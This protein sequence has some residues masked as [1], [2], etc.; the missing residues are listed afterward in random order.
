MKAGDFIVCFQSFIY[1]L[2]C[3]EIKRVQNIKIA[4]LQVKTITDTKKIYIKLN[5]HI[6]IVILK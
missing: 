2:I 4:G 6:S 3:P 5:I 1:L